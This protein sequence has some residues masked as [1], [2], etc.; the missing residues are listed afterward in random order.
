[1]T[2]FNY[3]SPKEFE[4]TMK[5][6]VEEVENVMQNQIE[7]QKEAGT[8]LS[9]ESILKSYPEEFPIQR[10]TWYSYKGFVNGRKNIN[11]KT[12]NM[13][14]LA[15][16]CNYT[17]IS[18]DYFLGKQKSKTAA[19]SADAM[20]EE[21]G[22]SYKTLNKLLNAKEHEDIVIPERY[23]K[24]SESEYIEFL[25][26]RFS[27][28]FLGHLLNYFEALDKFDEYWFNHYDPKTKKVLAE[29]LDKEDVTN[30][31][32]NELQDNVR[33]QL[34][35]ICNKVIDFFEEFKNEFAPEE[36]SKQESEEVEE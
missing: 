18:A 21:F 26:N 36:K 24:V 17:N 16:V 10:D 35:N 23:G 22:L 27:G 6:I 13:Q 9:H 1:M 30:D 3:F 5:R 14:V 25:I 7:E 28:N 12:I 2:T 34:F 8:K 19:S 31:K 29:Y 15:D 20:E 11:F 4:E 32:K 33:F